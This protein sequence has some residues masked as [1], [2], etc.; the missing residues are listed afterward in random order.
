M[1][2]HLNGGHFLVKVTFVKPVYCTNSIDIS[3]K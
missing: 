2:L 3:P 1:R